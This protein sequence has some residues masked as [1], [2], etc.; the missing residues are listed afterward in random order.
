M[1]WSLY[2]GPCIFAPVFSP[3]CLGPAALTLRGDDG[4]RQLRSVGSGYQPD[5]A[6]PL[7]LLLASRPRA[8][9]SDAC[10]ALT[11]QVEALNSEIAG[12]QCAVQA[13][14]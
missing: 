11:R 9:A 10:P 4:P 3:W 2:R 13:L 7:V 5:P 8:R 12:L 1:P 14:A 6:E